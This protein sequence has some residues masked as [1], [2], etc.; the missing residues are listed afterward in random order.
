[1][2]SAD[3]EANKVSA[4]VQAKKSEKDP[5]LDASPAKVPTRPAPVR[6]APHTR[7]GWSPDGARADKP[8]DCS[9]VLGAKCLACGR[10]ARCPG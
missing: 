1:M 3:S 7:P 8:A 5:V 2:S 10:L 9:Q 4:T 6:Y